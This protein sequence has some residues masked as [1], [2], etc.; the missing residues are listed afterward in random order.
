MLKWFCRLFKVRPRSSS[1]SPAL[2]DLVISTRS[3]AV[4]GS[5]CQSIK[6]LNYLAVISDSFQWVPGESASQPYRLRIVVPLQELIPH[7]LLGPNSLPSGYEGMLLHLIKGVPDLSSFGGLFFR[8]KV[9]V[10]LFGFRLD[11]VRKCGLVFF[12]RQSAIHTDKI[13]SIQIMFLLHGVATRFTSFENY[14]AAV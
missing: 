9:I 2:A 1:S 3:S 4:R 13:F 12:S 7:N 8:S 10:Q 6:V 11:H 5:E 14:I